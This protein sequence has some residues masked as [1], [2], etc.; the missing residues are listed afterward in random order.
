[1]SG[2]GDGNAP[3]RNAA[4]RVHQAV[5]PR[6]CSVSMTNDSSPKLPLWVFVV[7][8]VA[9]LA[10]A[11]LIAE[12]SHHPLSPAALSAVAGC[13]AL[14][15]LVLL[16]PLLVR[17]ERQKNEVLDERQRS[18]EGIAR[19]VQESAEQLSIAANGLNQIA[20]L[21][22]QS[23]QTAEAL[24]EKL[25]AQIDAFETKAAHANEGER[26]RLEKEL[27]ALRKTNGDQLAALAT[28]LAQTTAEWSKLETAS[29]AQL[30]RANESL[31]QLD[32]Q[33]ATKIANAHKQALTELDTRIEALAARVTAAAA[34]VTHP[35]VKF[36]PPATPPIA[37]STEPTPA[38]TEAS[39]VTEAASTV[40]V[41]AA[42]EP[43]APTAPTEASTPTPAPAAK[44][45]RKPRREQTPA[46][47]T[48]ETIADA[49]A[50][51][52]PEPVVSESPVTVASAPNERAPEST[53]P[54]PPAPSA[55]P[56]PAPVIAS[57]PIET[58]A[59]PA[60]ATSAPVVEPTSSPAPAAAIAAE[61]TPVEASTA[62]PTISAAPAAAVEPTPE[63][64]PVEA[65]RRRASRA[66]PEPEPEPTLDLAIDDST[67]PVRTIERGLSS[68]G[69]TRM[70][71]TAYIGIGNR[72]FIRGE[73]AGLSWDKG[74]PLQF[75]SI[76]KWRWE[77]NEASAPVR[78][79]LYKNDEQECS[80]LGEQ[81]LE[82]GHL[83]EMSAKF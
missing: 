83:Q 8:D 16:V 48:P 37:E 13:A 26:A 80:A 46:N 51:S 44:R 65:P 34:T 15:T 2:V 81:V 59:D 77:T 63:P 79:K 11:W 53:P 39:G 68:D 62:S 45:P 9:L 73:G 25:K 54:A 14:G 43:I 24:P 6:A 78:F 55:G 74:V 5:A 64:A 17:Y 19:T 30:T 57:A 10:A 42:I 28:Q 35:A 22:R 7:S 12:Y 21:A 61:P 47:A 4:R 67:P 1:V 38:P 66:K 58:P 23:L 3:G 33:A 60:P 41:S 50:A 70:I 18:L 76:G 75:V 52:A 29:R 32:Q 82:P 56:A 31:S 40:A 36:T 71:V 49:P 20:S 27:S 72:L 69:A